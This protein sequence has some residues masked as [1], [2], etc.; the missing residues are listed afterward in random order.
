MSNVKEN[1]VDVV[2][3][4]KEF[5]LDLAYTSINDLDVTM[6]FTDS[7]HILYHTKL[8]LGDNYKIYTKSITDGHNV[9]I[10]IRTEAKLKEYLSSNIE[11]SRNEYRKRIIDKVIS[12][13]VRTLD[14]Y[15]CTYSLVEDAKIIASYNGINMCI[16]INSNYH[17]DIEIEK[18]NILYLVKDT[19]QL[20]LLGIL[21][22]LVW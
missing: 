10:D 6:C 12:N 3:I 5:K 22:E 21:K 19:P 14:D 13:T 7:E 8:T 20:N 1:L 15:G 18:N 17:L 9:C 16:D 11:S 2:N 4:F